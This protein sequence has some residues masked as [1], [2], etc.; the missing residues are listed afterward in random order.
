VATDATD[1]GAQAELGLYL[2]R[3]GDER[4]ARRALEN[5]WALDKSDVTTKN[6]LDMMDH[7]D[8][9]EVVPDGDLIF[10]FPKDEA[11]VLKAY[12][13]P[14]GEQAMKTYTEQYGFKPAGPILVE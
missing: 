12:A 2:L 8:T 9:F 6:L 14:L 11:A 4:E 1:A 7:L 13:L 3:T 5:S 10:K